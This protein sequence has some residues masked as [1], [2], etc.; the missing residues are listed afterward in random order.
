VVAVP[1]EIAEGAVE[2]VIDLPEKALT[3]TEPAKQA[4]SAAFGIPIEALLH[5][6]ISY[7]MQAFGISDKNWWI[8]ILVKIG[9]P[10]AVATGFVL[11]KLPASKLV[12]TASVMA[13]ITAIVREALILSGVDTGS[14]AGAT[15]PGQLSQDIAGLMTNNWGKFTSG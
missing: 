1:K 15:T 4:F 5:Q 10:T 6:G 3:L 9:V 2:A 7:L 14:P 13:I 11:G 8:R 12:A